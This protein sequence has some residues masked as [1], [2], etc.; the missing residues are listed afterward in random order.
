MKPVALLAVTVA[1]AVLWRRTRPSPKRPP[2]GEGRGFGR[3]P[4]LLI[5]TP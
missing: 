3:N 5:E 4:Y 2:W 1:A